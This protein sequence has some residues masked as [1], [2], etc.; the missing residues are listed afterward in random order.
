VGEPL[1]RSVR[2]LTNNAMLILVLAMVVA[3]VGF[4]VVFDWLLHLEY[5]NHPEDWNKDGQPSGFFWTPDGATFWRGSMSRSSVASS[6]IFN[7]P[8]WVLGDQRAK[9]LLF[10]Y[11]LFWWIFMI[12]WVGTV[13][14]MIVTRSSN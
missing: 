5:E 11:R 2:D 6:L 7:T 3:G 10:C 8:D 14:E 12:G 4:F 13:I 1:K 9:R